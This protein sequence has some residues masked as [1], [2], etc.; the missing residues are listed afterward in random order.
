MIS[1]KDPDFSKYFMKALK[2]LSDKYKKVTLAESIS[3]YPTP[4]EDDFC[5]WDIKK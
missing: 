1:T 4:S 2:L 5:Y 3:N